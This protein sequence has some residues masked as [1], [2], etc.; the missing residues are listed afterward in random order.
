MRSDVA[1]FLP[2]PPRDYL[3]LFSLTNGECHGYGIVKQVEAMTGSTVTMDPS[4]LYRSIKR[5]IDVGLVRETKIA[6]TDSTPGPGR[7]RL[8]AITD[9]GAAV[10]AAEAER[11][12]RLTDAARARRLIPGG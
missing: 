7:R 11:L 12:S 5:L 10:V 6:K 3:V 1:S 4:N 2:V 8:Y 9:L